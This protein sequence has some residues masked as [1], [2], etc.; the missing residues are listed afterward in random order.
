[1]SRREFMRQLERLLGDIPAS[2]REEALEYYEGYF[3][4][5]GPEKE[6]SVI[7]EL[8][9]PERVAAEIKAGLK[10]DRESGRFT[11]TGYED[12]RFEE[13]AF[14]N[15]RGERWKGDREKRKD[16]LIVVLL[17]IVTFPIWS[18]LLGVVGSLFLGIF[19]AMI[20]IVM[21]A[22]LGALALGVLFIACLTIGVTYVGTSLGIGVFVI[23][24]G[25]I[26]LALGIV[27]FAILVWLL[28][29]AIPALLRLAVDLVQKLIRRLRGG[30][31]R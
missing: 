5:A 26:C 9:S 29:K 2:D 25:F 15:R 12:E 28:F 19:G 7:E 20:A 11:D 18:T 3:E 6:S 22:F 17:L 8:G 23:G 30:K 16:L 27:S 31:K 13:R 24:A 10:N 14:P 4:D 1:M 21:A